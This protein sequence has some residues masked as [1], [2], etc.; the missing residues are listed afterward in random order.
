MPCIMNIYFC[1]STGKKMSYP[2][3]W[4][5]VSETLSENY[6]EFFDDGSMMHD[7]VISEPLGVIAPK[8]MVDVAKKIYNM[9]VRSD[10]IWIVTFPKCGTTWT[11]VY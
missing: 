5:P 10:D 4:R 2:F 6:K 3:E 8:P 11:Q 7:A 9:D 1:L